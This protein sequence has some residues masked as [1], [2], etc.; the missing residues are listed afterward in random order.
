M[1]EIRVIVNQNEKKKYQE[2]AKFFGLSESD[3]GKTFMILGE[4]EITE[5]FHVP[6]EQLKDEIR[7]EIR[8]FLRLLD[9]RHPTYLFLEEVKIKLNGERK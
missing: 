5:E 6:I 1:P 9:K 2:L 7:R 8:T 4:L 3:L